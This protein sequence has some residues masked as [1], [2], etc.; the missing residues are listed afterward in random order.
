MAQLN[1]T[2]N[3]EEILQLL[4]QDHDDAFRTLLQN[5]LNAVLKAESQEQLKANPYER[6]EERTDS[7]NGFRN[8]DLTT[9]IG[10]ITLAVPRHRNVPFKT[11]IFENYARSEASLVAIARMGVISVSN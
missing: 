8:R 9:R 6:S 5:S 3:Q 4:S 7:R 10:K 1:I 11:M 2:L